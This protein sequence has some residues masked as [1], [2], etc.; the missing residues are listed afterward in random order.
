[1]RKTLKL[2][3]F[4]AILL[5]GFA[6]APAIYA[7]DTDSPRGGM[8][9]PGMMGQGSMMQGGQ[10]GMMNMTNMLGPMGPIGQMMANCNKM[11]QSMMPPQREPDQ[12]PKNEG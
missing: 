8:M 1:M 7:H 6:L 12:G 9:G 4:A 11:M 3:A 10:G 2:V 5:T